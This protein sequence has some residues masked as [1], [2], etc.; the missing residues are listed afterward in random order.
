MKYKLLPFMGKW[1]CSAFAELSKWQSILVAM[2]VPHTLG[3]WSMASKSAHCMMCATATYGTL[4]LVRSYMIAEMRARAIMHLRVRPTDTAADLKIAFPDQCNWLKRVATPTTKL[5]ALIKAA[6]YTGPLEML[7]CDM[8]IFGG[9]QSLKWSV[10]YIL[11]NSSKIRRVS[12]DISESR[13]RP[14]H[15]LIALRTAMQT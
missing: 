2:S 11:A 8:C 10:E 6:G 13:E 15:P 3:E 14:A 1:H 7:T 12:K 9:D 4:W 5:A